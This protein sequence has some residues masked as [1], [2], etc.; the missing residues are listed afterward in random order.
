MR[1]VKNA[2]REGLQGHDLVGSG[3]LV[4]GKQGDQLRRGD[5]GGLRDE[6]RQTGQTAHQLRSGVLDLEGPQLLVPVPLGQPPP[7]GV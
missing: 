3:E 6:S 2:E 4:P 1:F 5:G 7:V